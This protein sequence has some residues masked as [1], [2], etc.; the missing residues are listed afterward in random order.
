[1]TAQRGDTLIEVL[2]GITLLSMVIVGALS[3]MS[4]GIA[5]AQGAVEHSETRVQINAQAQLLEYLRDQYIATNKAPGLWSTIL[6]SSSPTY[7]KDIPSVTNEP[8]QTDTTCTPLTDKQPFYLAQTTTGNTLNPPT[9]ATV[10]GTAQTYAQPSQGLWIEAYRPLD[11]AASKKY[12]DF[13]IKGC[14]Q[15]G[16][17]GPLQVEA[18][19]VR[20]YDGN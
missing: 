13:V 12:I 19:V 10:I 16:G 11:V 6:T 1:M 20:L 2:L 14:W 17:N 7:V 3:L 4:F 5:Q 8:S 9:I 15:G 18:S